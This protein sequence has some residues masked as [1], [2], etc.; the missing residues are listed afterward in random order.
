MAKQTKPY[1]IN[2]GRGIKAKVW[3]NEGNKGTWYN[4]TFARCYKD[5]EGEFQ[6]SGSYGRDDLLHV[7]RAA[8]KAFDRINEQLHTEDE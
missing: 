2:I 8:E 4:V 5:E 6:D 3:S 7:A 1:T